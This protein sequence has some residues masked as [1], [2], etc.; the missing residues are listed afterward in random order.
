ML[1]D[2]RNG[3]TPRLSTAVRVGVRGGALLVRFDGKDDGCV[4]TLT[5]RDDPLWKEDVFE[6]FL[7]PLDPPAVYYEF[8]VNPLGA[9]FDARVESR[10]GRRATMRADVSW[11]CPGFSARVRR[12]AAR[13]SALL[14]IPLAPMGG[15]RSDTWRANFFRIDRGETDEYTAWSPTMADPPDFHVPAKFGYLVLP[16]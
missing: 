9:L 3:S 7:S 10:E 15:E 11:D 8:E 14:K 6:V 16:S 5:R 2:A 12:R 4:A 1:R 13:W